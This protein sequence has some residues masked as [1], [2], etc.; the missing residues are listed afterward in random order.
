MDELYAMPH[1]RVTASMLP[2]HIDKYVTMLGTVDPS[3]ISSDGN[4]FQLSV[5]DRSIEVVMNTPLNELLD[6]VV[7]ITGKV[8][9][10]CHLHCAIY[11]KLTSSV[12]FNVEE[13]NKAL[14]MINKFPKCYT[15]AD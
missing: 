7:E 3:R 4:S 10:R 8:D 5:G 13:Y 1:P 11:R 6:D 9:N 14:E 2:K 12:P 15:Y